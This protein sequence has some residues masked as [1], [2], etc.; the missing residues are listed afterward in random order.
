MNP[1]RGQKFGCV[2]QNIFIG[3]EYAA[4]DLELL[5]SYN[6]YYIIDLE[7]RKDI[8]KGNQLFTYINHEMED[9]SY[10]DKL[11]AQLRS[12]F[13]DIDK[14]RGNNVLVY[15]KMAE[16]RSVVVVMAYLLEKYG[17]TLKA[18]LDRLAKLTFPFPNI[19]M[20]EYL[21]KLEHDKFKHN[22]LNYIEWG[23]KERKWTDE[24]YPISLEIRKK[25]IRT[26]KEF[27]DKPGLLSSEHRTEIEKDLEKAVQE[28][29]EAEN[30]KQNIIT[31]GSPNTFDGVSTD[32][33]EV[34]ESGAIVAFNPTQIIEIISSSESDSDIEIIN[35]TVKKIKK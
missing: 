30:Q 4:S 6:C 16:S 26:K 1:K 29:E 35:E 28:R 34:F 12:I 19:I 11:P 27:D 32:I 23:K 31:S 14:A 7:P 18:T 8:Y 15:C 22:T 13:S 9:S 21:L 24:P 33:L 17:T 25:R 5:A 20:G 3:N 10:I 2:S